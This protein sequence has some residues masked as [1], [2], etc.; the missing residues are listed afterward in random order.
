NATNQSVIR[1]LLARMGFACEIVENGH[2]AL[3]AYE[4][5]PFGILLTDFHMPGMNGLELTGRIREMETLTGRPRVPIVALTA[6]A[7]SGVA[8]QCLDAGMDE[9]LTKPID[10]EKLSGLLQ[11][12]VPQALPL[13]R[14]RRER[15]A[16][17]GAANKRAV[18]SGSGGASAV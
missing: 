3:S 5:R 9:Y 16:G 8:Q 15:E 18:A 14:K 17:R 2:Q 4:L 7:L 13:R 12:Y 1:Q 10:S 6:D 11:R